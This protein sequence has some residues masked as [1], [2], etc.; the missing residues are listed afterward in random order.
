MKAPEHV[1]ELLEPVIEGLGYECVG[2]EFQ[3]GR[4]DACLRVFID[5]PAGITVDDC[6]RVSHQVSGVLDVE[7]PIAGDY[8]LEVSS[9]GLDRPVFK[10]SDYQRFAGET[11]RLRLRER[12][13]GQR[14]ISGRLEGLT[15]GGVAVA[16]E[17]GRRVVP[18]EAIDNA[19]IELEP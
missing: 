16:S 13:D 7:D 18:L 8:H 19:H 9:P 15:D 2:L 11:V 12:I 10:S 1:T 3:P 5:A 4:R 17:D 6:A 14:R